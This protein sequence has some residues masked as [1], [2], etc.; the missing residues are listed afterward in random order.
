[1]GFGGFALM[2]TDVSD[3]AWEVVGAVGAGPEGC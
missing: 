3:A 2:G 1:M